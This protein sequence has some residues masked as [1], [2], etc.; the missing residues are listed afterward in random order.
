MDF[1]QPTND[2]F[3][4]CTSMSFSYG[5][6]DDRICQSTLRLRFYDVK[7]IF[8]QLFDKKNYKTMLL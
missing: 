3:Y 7:Q 2:F 6:A 4:I 1:N 8:I 5:D